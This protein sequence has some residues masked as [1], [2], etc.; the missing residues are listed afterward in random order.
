MAKR[1]LTKTTKER[2]KLLR[3]IRSMEKRGYRFPEKELQKIHS[4][5][6]YQTFHS[7][8]RDNY[9][10]LYSVATGEI[11]GKTVTGY[12][13]RSYERKQAALKATE[14]RKQ[15]ELPDVVRKE[16]P[17]I[18]E[19]EDQLYG[20]S[21]GSL[22]DKQF[23]DWIRKQK[24]ATDLM[25]VSDIQEGDIMFKNIEEM[26]DRFT[27]RG[28]ANILKDAL[29][30]EIEK[31]GRNKVLEAMANAPGD[32]IAEAQNIMFYEGD[33]ADKHRA[34]VHFF[35]SIVGEVR[36]LEASKALGEAT[37]RMTDLYVP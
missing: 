32:I 27:V 25:T 30:S 6:Y 29:A 37:D 7:Y 22:S 24:D 3:Q 35:D 20:K 13:F 2:G 19:L 16:A 14:T 1:K 34:L 31:Y 26:I 8:T 9:E 12:E 5:K 36:T 23:E 33:K 18:Q 11:D 21:V 4:G 10:K 28:G 15:K 17:S